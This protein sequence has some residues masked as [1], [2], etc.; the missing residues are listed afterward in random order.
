M[1]PPAKHLFFCSGE[2]FLSKEISLLWTVRVTK[3]VSKVTSDHW[4]Y[5][6]KYVCANSRTLELCFL[7]MHFH[8]ESGYPSWM[9]S[10]VRVF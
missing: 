5:E 10:L 3:E 6:H 7:T 8:V 4:H 2:R 9:E 1:L